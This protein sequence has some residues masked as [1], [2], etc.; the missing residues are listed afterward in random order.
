MAARLPALYGFRRK[1]PSGIRWSTLRGCFRGSPPPFG[2]RSHLGLACALTLTIAAL[3]SGCTATQNPLENEEN[4]LVR[5]R[6]VPDE[7]GSRA[8]ELLLIHEDHSDFDAL[9]AANKN[10][11]SVKRIP[12]DYFKALVECLADDEFFEM[13]GGDM[14]GQVEHDRTISVETP[15]TRWFV[16][17]NPSFT[18]EDYERFNSMFAVIRE[19]H[20]AVPTFQVIDNQQG[21][22]YFLEELKRLRLERERRQREIKKENEKE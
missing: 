2:T 11:A 6:A 18:L 1:A 16:H 5:Y 10:R 8:V 19:C 13:A 3:F 17:K 22:E 21:G 14:V 12:R 9:L 20:D 4:V 7:P 15:V